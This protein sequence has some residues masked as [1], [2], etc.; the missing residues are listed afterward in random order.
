M[1]AV[2]G[3]DIQIWEPSQ[4]KPRVIPTGPVRSL[5]F[6]PDGTKMLLATEDGQLR[7]WDIAAEDFTQLPGS[8]SAPVSAVA[9]MEDGLR[10]AAGTEVGAIVVGPL[11]GGPGNRF[12][13]HES[14]VG[15][16]ALSTTHV[17]SSANDGT[18][19]LSKLDGTLVA[20][21]R[22][23]SHFA[24]IGLS[25]DAGRV[26]LANGE[27]VELWRVRERQGRLRSNGSDR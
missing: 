2:A 7:V 27:R 5:C 1:V 25:R 26:M 3:D 22:A 20:R 8:I 12:T 15:A 9:A 11:D 13:C 10:F 16:L 4:R 21:W 19:C 24:G 17:L 6:T 18:A 23:S 14:G